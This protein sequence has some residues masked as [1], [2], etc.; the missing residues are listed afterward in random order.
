MDTRNYSEQKEKLSRV[1]YVTCYISAYGTQNG[2]SNRQMSN[3][4]WQGFIRPL[5][6]GGLYKVWPCSCFSCRSAALFQYHFFST[7]WEQVCLD[8]SLG[9]TTF[10]S[11]S[12]DCPWVGLVYLNFDFKKY[13]PQLLPRLQTYFPPPHS[14]WTYA[15]IYSE[16]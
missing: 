3:P 8:G 12:K 9:P 2:L 13:L 5:L 14:H 15:L 6:K 4:K 10:A 7:T 16:D 1:I 11:K